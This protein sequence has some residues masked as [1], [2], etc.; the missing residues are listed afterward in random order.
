MSENREKTSSERTTEHLE[1]IDI[2]QVVEEVW[3]G[4]KKIWWLILLLIIAGAARSYFATSGSYTPQYVASATMSVTTPYGNGGYSDTQS[5]SEMAEI[6]PYILTSGVLADVVAQD[7]GLDSVPGSISASAEEGTNLLTISVS[8]GEPQMAYDILMSVIK[9][10]PQVTEFIFGETNL[11]ILDETGVPSDTQ[12]EIIIRGSYRR[13]AVQGAIVGAVILCVYVLI[14]KNVKSRDKLRRQINVPDLG[15]LP[16]IKA[17]KRKNEAYN[18]I[19]ML[20]ERIEPSYLEA[21]RRLRIRVMKHM[22]KG[23]K[24]V[25]MVTSSV[26]GEGKTTVAVNLAVSLAKQEKKVILVDCDPRNPSVAGLMNENEAHPGIG[27][28]LSGKVSLKEALVQ[29]KIQD[30]QLWI[31]YGGQP[32]QKDAVLLGSVQM[33]EVV[34]QLKADAD[35]V[36][37]DAAPTEMLADASLMARYT[38]AVLYVIRYDYLK[39]Y[40]IRKGIQTLAMSGTHILGY[41]F[42]GDKTKKSDKYGYGY[43]YGYKSYSRYGHYGHYGKYRDTGKKDDN[44]GRVIKD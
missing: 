39:M 7:M 4:F 34:E 2:T 35:Y 22:E 44:S 16:Y 8:S 27:S 43:G 15:S 12:R 9:N 36:I 33:R 31:L 38:D 23:N 30:G 1:K 6:F 11:E 13:G 42:N 32:N 40:R 41:V 24:K 28:V 21:L 29:A 18:R 14:K 3:A 25:L 26:P 17:K 5:A 19:N 10:Y 37:L 20:N